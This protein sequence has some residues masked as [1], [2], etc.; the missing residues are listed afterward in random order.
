V[1][2]PGLFKVI[3]LHLCPAGP[4]RFAARTTEKIMVEEIRRCVVIGGRV[5]AISAFPASSKD[6]RGYDY[7]D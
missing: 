4:C 2:T 3:R 6:E 5:G 1:P 7:D